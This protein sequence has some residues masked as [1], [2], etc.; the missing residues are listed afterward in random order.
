MTRLFL[1]S[2]L[3]AVAMFV[4]GAGFWTCPIPFVYVERPSV[5]EAELAQTLRQALP[6]DGFYRI[7]SAPGDRTR[8]APSH[9]EGPVVSIHYRRDGFDV[10]APS[11]LAAG[12]LHG[13]GTTFLLAGLLHLAAR[14]RF[15]QRLLLVSLAGV[16][17]ASFMV[18]GPG[19]YWF[20]PWPW[21]LLNAAYDAAAFVIAGAVLAAVVK[22]APKRPAA[23]SEI[24]GGA[25]RSGVD[26]GNQAR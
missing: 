13:W 1:G 6:N 12:F 10:M 20:H 11:V 7:P 22:P 25:S 3:A 14:P 4:F 17:G 16:A 15:G 26:H 2:F 19:I 5:D 24:N 8:A 23:A 9:R 21:L 18:L